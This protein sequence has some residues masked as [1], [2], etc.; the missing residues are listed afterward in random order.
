MDIGVM[1]YGAFTSSGALCATSLGAGCPG[2]SRR[3]GRVQ[4]KQASRS[5]P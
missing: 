1:F 2:I 3:A 5:H 4:S